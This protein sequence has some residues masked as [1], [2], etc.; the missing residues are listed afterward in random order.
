MYSTKIINKNV[1]DGNAYITINDPY[2][3]EVPNPF[4]NTKRGKDEKPPVPFQ[5]KMIPQNA[6][7]GH[8]SK[9]QYGGGGYLEATRYITAQPLDARKKGFGSHDAKR[10]DEFANA[11]RTEQYRATISKESLIT[12]KAS[13]N[14]QATLTKLLEERAKTTQSFGGAGESGGLSGSSTFSY[15]SAVPQYDI[16]RSRVTPFDPRSIKDTYYKFSGDREKRFGDYRPSSVDFGDGAWGV[17]YKPPSHGGRSET[18][19]FLD[20]SHLTV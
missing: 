18:K 2:K 17:T 6:E 3:D 4:R 15:S 13:G 12:S 19:N 16:G 7:N 9:L 8:F 5:I 10:R 20:K 11:N 14:L 1:V